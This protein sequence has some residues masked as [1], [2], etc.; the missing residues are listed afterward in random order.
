MCKLFCMYLGAEW[1]VKYQID[2]MES[3]SETHTKMF[4]S[5]AP[6]VKTEH[7]VTT[8]GLALHVLWLKAH[9]ELRPLVYTLWQS[10]SVG[11]IHYVVTCT[12]EEGVWRELPCYANGVIIIFIVSCWYN[13]FLNNSVSIYSDRQEK[14][15]VS[16]SVVREWGL[17]CPAHISCF[18][19]ARPVSVS[20]VTLGPPWDLPPSSPSSLPP[21]LPL[22]TA[23]GQSWR[24]CVR[25]P[26]QL[27]V[28]DVCCLQNTE[29]LFALNLSSCSH[30]ILHKQLCRHY[31]ERDRN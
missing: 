8:R 4:T 1:A 29:T 18:N 3:E 2:V 21:S 24:A 23:R 13:S 30:N 27:D 17:A 31:E 5:G 9:G 12:M 11:D 26:C 16:A 7:S 20:V 10:G 25:V 15:V 28:S 19:T 6:H 14:D 22:P